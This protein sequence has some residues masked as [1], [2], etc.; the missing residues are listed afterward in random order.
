MLQQTFANSDR[1][2]KLGPSYQIA[3]IDVAAI[4]EATHVSK[5]VGAVFFLPLF[6]AKCLQMESKDVLAIKVLQKVVAKCQSA[7]N[8]A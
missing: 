8:A 6:N 5:L 1:P 7:G 4:L 3:E 2:K